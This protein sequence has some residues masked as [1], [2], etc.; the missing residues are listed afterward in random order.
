MLLLMDYLRSTR[1]GPTSAYSSVKALESLKLEFGHRISIK[2]YHT[3][4]L[5]GWMKKW[6]PPRFNETVGLLHFKIYITDD[7]MILTGANLSHDYFTRRQDRYFQITAPAVVQ[8]Y[9]TYVETVSTLAFDLTTTLELHPPTPNPMTSP[10]VF[11]SQAYQRLSAILSPTFSSQRNN[12]ERPPLHENTLILPAFQAG[13]L[14]IHQ[15]QLMMQA[16]WKGVLQASTSMT[17]PSFHPTHLPLRQ[18]PCQTQVWL[19]SGYFNLTQAWSQLLLKGGTFPVHVLTASPKANSFYHSKG[20]SKWIPDAYSYLERTFLS[21][22]YQHHQQHRIDLKEYDRDQWTYHAKGVWLSPSTSRA[23]TV[24]V[25]GSSNFGYRSEARDLEAQLLLLTQHP[26]LQ[27]QLAREVEGLWS[28]G[29]PMN[30]HLL[31]QRPIHWV[32]KCVAGLVRSM[33]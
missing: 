9:C 8:H 26:P 32:A 29:K 10:H 21:R 14:A 23:P 22:V 18:S 7:T 5:T 6:I 12:D 20:I 27:A 16:F 17:T 4:D 3:P 15:D 11:R 19:T 30:L 25:I 31:N 13:P 1:E 24:T 33:L 2:F 28:F